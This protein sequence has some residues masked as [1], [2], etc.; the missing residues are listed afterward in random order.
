MK[1]FHLLRPYRAKIIWAALIAAVAAGSEL[2]LPALMSEI[3][4]VGIFGGD[5]SYIVRLTV[6]MAILSLAGLAGNI[7]ARKLSNIVASRYSSDVRYEIFRKVNTF[8]TT[9][10]NKFGASA[11]LTRST[12]DVW[13]LRETVSMMIGVVVYV[14]AL[15]I[16]GA[17]L[18]F[19]KSPVL[20][21]IM[22][23]ASAL[24]VL[25]LGLVGRRMYEHWQRADKYID[26]QNK[27]MRERL[28]GIRVIRAFNREGTEQER[29]ADATRKMAHYIIRSNVIIGLTTPAVILFLNLA[30]VAAVYAGAFDVFRGRGVPAG[31]I[32]AVIQYLTLITNA[33]LG[34]TF[35]AVF[36]PRVRANAKRMNEIF[37][38]E[39]KDP[40]DSKNAVTLSGEIE[41]KN[42][43]LKY[44]GAD[45]AALSE[46]NVKV[47]KGETVAFIG[48]N[49]SGKST[50]VRLLTGLLKPTEGEIY[51]DGKSY[52]EFAPKDI[53]DNIACV[54][55]K[56]VIFQGAV[57][58]NIAMGKE[59]VS[60]EEALSAAE[61]AEMGDFLKEHPEGINYKITENGS[62]LSGG[63]KQ[64]LA[65]ARALVRKSPINIFDDSFSSLDFLTESRLKR[66]LS[67]VLEGKT[68]IIVTQRVATAMS[69][70]K[71]YVFDK[72]KIIGAGTH[73]NL[74]KACP[75]YEEIYKS[76]TG[77]D[78]EMINEK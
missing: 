65:I 41:L 56:P 22:L 62:N 21:G 18:A 5:F 27:L 9:E 4:D 26:V 57:L 47:P 14:P 55:Q 6:Y 76:Q 19:I 70:S 66:K 51:F 8:S 23:V 58:E 3:V 10:F 61:A 77:G 38:A 71:I 7:V 32:I 52:K 73:R 60:E 59:G 78:L 69:A 48:G 16:G 25:S 67:K 42:V 64:R 46:V 44:E 15:M 30:I 29:I 11:L 13:I 39:G 1:I 40:G 75:F 45:E 68:Q 17:I 35:A 12:E 37:A 20:A 74:L 36:L 33:T 54:Y 50:V 43:S 53:R 24:S 63:Q 28:G 49:G 34:F 2:A 31:D 72:G